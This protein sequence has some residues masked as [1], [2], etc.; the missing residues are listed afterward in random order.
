MPTEERSEEYQISVEHNRGAHLAR[1]LALCSLCC[2]RPLL[3]PAAP[4]PGSCAS[5]TRRARSWVPR[6]NGAP[7]WPDRAYSLSRASTP[8]CAVARICAGP[9]ASQRRRRTTVAAAAA[10]RFRSEWLVFSRVGTGTRHRM[11]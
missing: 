10:L 7:R 1:S 2:R 9:A 6:L 4:A 5:T 3:G 11:R 8:R